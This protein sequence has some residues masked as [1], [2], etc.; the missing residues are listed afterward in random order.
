MA[1]L[2]SRQECPPAEALHTSQDVKSLC[3]CRASHLITDVSGHTGNL[4]QSTVG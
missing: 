1:S 2:N 4:Q 3:A